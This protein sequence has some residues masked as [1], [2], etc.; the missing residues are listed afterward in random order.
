MKSQVHFALKTRSNINI[1]STPLT[2]FAGF[3]LPWA[4]TVWCNLTMYTMPEKT[5]HISGKASHWRERQISARG[6][7]CDCLL[8]LGMCCKGYTHYSS[9]LEDVELIGE[10]WEVEDGIRRPVLL[11]DS[12]KYRWG[13]YVRKA[14]LETKVVTLA[15]FAMLNFTVFSASVGCLKCHWVNSFHFL[16]VSFCLGQ[17]LVEH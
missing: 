1:F 12:M 15:T 8:H 6:C 7:L 2:H 17:L 5:H 9:A 14:Q 13:D 16:K 10:K 11:S 4:E 3:I